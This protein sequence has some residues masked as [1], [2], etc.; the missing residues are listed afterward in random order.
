MADA[1]TPRTYTFIL[2]WTRPPVSLNDRLHY[3]T[4]ATRINPKAESA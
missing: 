3:R 2:P 1:V 4:E